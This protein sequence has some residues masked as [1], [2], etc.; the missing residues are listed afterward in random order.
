MT[1]YNWNDDVLKLK[2]INRKVYALQPFMFT[3]GVLNELTPH[4]YKSRYC[5]D[6]LAEAMLFWDKYDGSQTPIVGKD[7]C[8]AIK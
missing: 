4:T 8:T 7:G 2:V 3:Y 6:S 1:L 5:F